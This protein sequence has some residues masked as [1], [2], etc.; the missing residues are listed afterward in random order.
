MPHDDLGVDVDRVPWATFQSEFFVDWQQGEHVSLIGPTGLGKTTLALAVLPRRT[1]TVI[2]AT[3]PSGRDATLAALT[4]RGAGYSVARDWPPPPTSR[5]VLLWPP[6]RRM[7]DVRRQ[8]DVF[9]RTLAAVYRTGGWCV[10]LDELAYV[11]NTLRLEGAMELLWQQGRSLGVSVVASTQ[12]P[13]H[14]P[15]MLYDQATHLF[16]WRDNDERNLKRLGGIGWLSRKEI[17]NTV[18]RLG[19]HE[20]LYVNARTGAMAVTRVERNR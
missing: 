16:F 10:Y 13:A 19:I 7:E 11:T 3:K 5:R 9:A 1:N 2:F 20:V 12:R 4:R 17:V 15:L 18:A 6:N 14:V 8:Q